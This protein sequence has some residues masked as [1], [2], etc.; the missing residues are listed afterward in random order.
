MFFSYQITKHESIQVI[1]DEINLEYKLV[2]L[3]QKAINSKM[4]Q[5]F[6]IAHF[7]FT[8]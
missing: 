5:E 2:Q 4:Y 6:L 3:S 8:Q 7:L 1:L